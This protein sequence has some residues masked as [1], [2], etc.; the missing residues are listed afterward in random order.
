[1]LKL[2]PNLKWLT[3]IDITKGTLRNKID[4]G[5]SFKLLADI[6]SMLNELSYLHFTIVASIQNTNRS[7]DTLHPLFKRVR[8]NKKLSVVIVSGSFY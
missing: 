5:F 1:M 6:L 8:Y 7:L 4:S 3:F 2:T